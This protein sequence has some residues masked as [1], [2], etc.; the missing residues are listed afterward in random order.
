MGAFGRQ[1]ERPD[2]QEVAG[3]PELIA[4]RKNIIEKSS[5]NSLNFALY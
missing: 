1:T 4:P 2:S 5:Y 3:R